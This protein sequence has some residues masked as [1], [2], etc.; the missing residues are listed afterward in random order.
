MITEIIARLIKTVIMTPP[1][2]L[3]IPGPMA[4]C[5]LAKGPRPLWWG[6]FLQKSLRAGVGR[7]VDVR[8]V[9][10]RGQ[11]QHCGRVASLSAL[12]VGR[13]VFASA[14]TTTPP[15][16]TLHRCPRGGGRVFIFLV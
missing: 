3:P 10:L 6:G 8:A 5:V 11:G 15:G 4:A 9:S 1:G 7:W 12:H 2:S 16:R 13:V 14:A